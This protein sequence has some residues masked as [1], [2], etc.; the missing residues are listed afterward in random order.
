MTQIFEPV[1]VTP[2]FYQL[3]TPFFPMYLSLGEQGMLIEG[4]ISATFDIVVQQI[5][6]LGIDPSRISYVALTHSHTDH[7]GALPRLKALWPHLKTIGSPTA[8]KI[9]SNEKML[10]QFKAVDKGISEILKSKSEIETLPEALEVY[11][12]SVDIVAR[13]ND[14]FDLG[15]GIAWKAHSIPG[16]A[17]CQ[18]AF[19]EEKEGTL[20]T[21]DATGFYNPEEN[22]FW[23]NYFESL[24]QYV[25]SLKKLAG[26][27]AKRAAL[28]HN[29]VVQGDVAAFLGKALKTTG[30]YHREMIQRTANGET[31]EAIAREKAAWVQRIADHMPYF[32]MPILCEVL[33]K[34]SQKANGNPDLHFEV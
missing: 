2:H 19:Y 3:G 30:D 18:M 15:D 16:H 32:V 7:I 21:G 1:K 29:G 14:R 4:G 20:A 24:D 5:K 28:S 23:P 8:S 27:P 33:I 11:D 10:K 6:T 25:G 12:F 34:Q 17:S 26:L 9:L 31:P 13:D 22:V